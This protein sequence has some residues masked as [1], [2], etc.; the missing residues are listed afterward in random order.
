[1]A[2]SSYTALNI[3]GS[4]DPGRRRGTTGYQPIHGDDSGDDVMLGI[5]GTKADGLKGEDDDDGEDDHTFMASGEEMGLFD[6]EWRPPNAG[7]MSSFLNM[8]N[9]IIGAGII[10]L[11]FA[12]REAGFWTGVFLLFSL[13]VIGP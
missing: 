5:R 3:D 10:G 6:T 9:S 12:F 7:F 8:A 11:P 2:P 4:R 1:M 13:T